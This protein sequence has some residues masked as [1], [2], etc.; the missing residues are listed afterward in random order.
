MIY[1][2]VAAVCVYDAAAA[3]REKRSSFAVVYRQVLSA[4][5]V[6]GGEGGC[7]GI[8]QKGGF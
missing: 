8:W 2:I 1:S 4:R 3:R 5:A 7:R 6:G